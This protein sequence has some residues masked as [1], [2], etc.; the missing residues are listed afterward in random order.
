MQLRI[1]DRSNEV[2]Y[3]TSSASSKCAFDLNG[4]W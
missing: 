4:I 3:G 1:S 2:D